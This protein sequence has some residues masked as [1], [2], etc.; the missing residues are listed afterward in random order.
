[1]VSQGCQVDPSPQ[2]YQHILDGVPVHAS[3]Q[4]LALGRFRLIARVSYR[5]TPHTVATPRVLTQ[6]WR[7]PP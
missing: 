3:G 2:G 1:M 6:K 7:M 5:G 4:D